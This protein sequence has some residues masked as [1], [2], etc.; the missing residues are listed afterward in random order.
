MKLTLLQGK[1][2]KQK[3]AKNESYGIPHNDAFLFS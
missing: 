2:S 1:K 3:Q